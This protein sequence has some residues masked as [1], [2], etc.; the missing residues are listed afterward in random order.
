MLHISIIL[1]IIYAVVITF[2]VWIIIKIIETTDAECDSCHGIYNGKKFNVCP[3]CS[4]T[5]EEKIALEL[6]SRG[7]SG[8]VICDILWKGTSLDWEDIKQLVQDMEMTFKERNIPLE[9]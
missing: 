6:L 4:R 8:T 2:I 7:L 1:G 5:R 9:N 3:D